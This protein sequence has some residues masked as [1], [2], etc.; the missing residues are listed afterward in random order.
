MKIA[1]LTVQVPYISGGAEILTEQLF[2]Q[3]R[4]HGHDP[5]IITIP[6]RWYP[7]QLLIDSMVMGNL[8][9]ISEAAYQKIDLMIGLKFPAYFAKH[10][11]K[12]L[13]LIHQHRQAYDLYKTK[14]GDLHQT[15]E[16]RRAREFLVQSDDK[17]LAIYNR[18]YTISKNVSDRLLKNNNLSSE[19]LYHPPINYEKLFCDRFENYIFYPSRIDLMKR[20]RLLVEA[21]KYL[22]SDI[23]IIIA[24]SGDPTETEFLKKM[25]KENNLENRV[26]LLGRV[27]EEDKILLYARAR[28][29]FFG[30]YDE[31]YGYI[32]LEALLSAK[33]LIV[34]EDAGC[35]TE[36][37]RNNES[38]YIIPAQA[39]I[40]AEKMDELSLN[41]TLAEK[42]GAAGLKLIQARNVSWDHTVNSLLG[43]TNSNNPS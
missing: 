31:D 9:E 4:L 7:P 12:V 40:L 18:R 25:I 36:F 13:W 19:A 24:G 2:Q 16:G 3:L 34:F 27:S 29:V 17:F 35:P 30:C 32:S 5:V 26:Q 21:A 22:K 20:Q 38:G 41:L 37:V 42:M 15:A 1:L 11:N 23:K 43:F 6:F 39:K 33:P 14:Y 10:P 8:I 28:A